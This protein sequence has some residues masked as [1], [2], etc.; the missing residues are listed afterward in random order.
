MPYLPV[1][2]YDT[3]LKI[4]AALGLTGLLFS[5]KFGW[6]GS[7]G[8]IFAILWEKIRGNKIGNYWY[9]FLIIIAGSLLM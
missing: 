3:Q 6:N 8:I 2:S 7:G 9:F 1:Q 4:M 5:L